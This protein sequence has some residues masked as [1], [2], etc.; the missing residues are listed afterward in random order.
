[1]PVPEFVNVLGLPQDLQ[2]QQRELVTSVLPYHTMKTLPGAKGAWART[3]QV[4][5]ALWE[6][7]Q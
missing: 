1:M 5:Q 3:E 6:D 4:A 7:S 2:A